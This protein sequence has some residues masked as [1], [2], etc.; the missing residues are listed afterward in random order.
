MMD[1]NDVTPAPSPSTEGNREEIRASLLSR[2]ESVLMAM[3]PAG[4]VKRGKFL[5]GDILGSPGD[6]LEQTHKN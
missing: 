5:I 3:F 6:S 2:L 1:F 4:K